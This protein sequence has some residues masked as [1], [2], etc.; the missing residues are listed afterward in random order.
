M[1]SGEARRSE[2]AKRLEK[3]RLG[4]KLIPFTGVQGKVRE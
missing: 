2:G 4:M 3:L 1:G